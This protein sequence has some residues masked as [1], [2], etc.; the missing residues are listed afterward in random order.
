MQIHQDTRSFDDVTHLVTTQDDQGLSPRTEK[1]LRG[2]LAGKWI[3]NQ[4]C[5]RGKFACMGEKITL[6]ILCRDQ[7]QL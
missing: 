2:I 3:V 7:G 1:Y 5:K 6:Y 4:S